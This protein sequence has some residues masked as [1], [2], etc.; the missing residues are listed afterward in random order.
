MTEKYVG[1]VQDIY[2][3]WKT[4]VRVD[5]GVTEEFKIELR[6][7]QGSVLSL[8]LSSEVMDRLT[9]PVRHESL[10]HDVCR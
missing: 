9:D 5:V 4:V 1:V 6:H 3:S 2:E 10:D 8:F 7:H